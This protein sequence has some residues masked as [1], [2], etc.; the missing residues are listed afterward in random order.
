MSESI[1]LDSE[2]DVF[3]VFVVYKCAYHRD[4]NH[5][6]GLDLSLWW[7]GHPPVCQCQHLHLCTHS[8]SV[9]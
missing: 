8:H 5:P 7:Y 9:Q 4:Q 1:V 3:F 2:C 6:R